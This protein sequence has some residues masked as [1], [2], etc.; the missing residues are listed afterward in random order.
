MQIIILT[1][2]MFKMKSNSMFVN[3]S[4]GELI[5]EIGLVEVLKNRQDILVCLDVI[6]NEA[7][8]ISGEFISPLICYLKDGAKNLIITPHIAGACLDSLHN[9]EE[10]CVSLL[11]E[12]LNKS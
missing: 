12:R 1:C 2:L 5:D 9:V 7:G 3:T 8:V 6:E 11:L 4:R 10:H